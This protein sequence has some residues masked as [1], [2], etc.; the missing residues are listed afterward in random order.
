MQVSRSTSLSL[1]PS[2]D[3]SDGVLLFR[4]RA[5]PVGERQ[6]GGVDGPG[7]KGKGVFQGGATGAP[8][9]RGGE[10]RD[11]VCLDV[12]D[13]PHTRRISRRG[14]GRTCSAA[15]LRAMLFTYVALLPSSSG[16]EKPKVLPT[17]LPAVASAVN[18]PPWRIVSS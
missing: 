1:S 8:E 3:G 12:S 17:G 2:R 14:N 4:C 15:P 9:S 5:G 13:G 7:C 10:E 16:M 11:L 18:R 6:S